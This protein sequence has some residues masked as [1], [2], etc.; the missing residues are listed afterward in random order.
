MLHIGH[1]KFK[2]GAPT[3]EIMAGLRG[4]TAVPGVISIVCGPTFKAERA[5]GFTHAMVVRLQSRE[6]LQILAVEAAGSVGTLAPG[7]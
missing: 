7:L 5:Q 1:F 6:A 4:L 2:A 3:E